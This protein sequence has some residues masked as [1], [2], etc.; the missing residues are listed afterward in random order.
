[1]PSG[2]DRASG[3]GSRAALPVADVF[4]IARGMV[5]GIAFRRRIHRQSLFARRRDFPCLRGSLP[6]PQRKVTLMN[7][8]V[9]VETPTARADGKRKIFALTFPLLELLSGPEQFNWKAEFPWFAC[10]F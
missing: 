4:T 6:F 9:P 7:A 3:A 5:P 8:R 10:V 2:R 1:M